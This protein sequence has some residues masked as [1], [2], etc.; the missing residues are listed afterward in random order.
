MVICKLRHI[1]MQG[2]NPQISGTEIAF[3]VSFITK[4]QSRELESGVDES[5]WNGRVRRHR[6]STY[7]LKEGEPD[8]EINDINPLQLIT[9]K[10]EI[11]SSIATIDYF[12]LFCR[13]APFHCHLLVRL[14][15]WTITRSPVELLG[16][17]DPRFF[18]FLLINNSS[19]EY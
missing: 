8:N 18:H 4:E 11:G 6:L 13:Q 5:T 9:T 1:E 10:D 7:R 17:T 16:V 14:S 2:T 12:H 3:G 15:S 19:R